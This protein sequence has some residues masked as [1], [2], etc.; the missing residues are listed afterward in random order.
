MAVTIIDNVATGMVRTKHDSCNGTGTIGVDKIETGLSIDFS[1]MTR[2]DLMSL[3]FKPVAITWQAGI[4]KISLS[5]FLT[6]HGE[7]EIDA[8]TA[9]K[10]V[11]TRAMRVKM[12]VDAGM[13][14]HVA[15][16]VVDNPGALKTV[17][18]GNV[19]GA[20]GKTAETA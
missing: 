4:R 2:E 8:K 10:Q 14:E 13:P 17:N 12:F 19:A 20:T 1:G 9:G 5:Q 15:E 3:A 18:F 6:F 11:L 7:H 16:L